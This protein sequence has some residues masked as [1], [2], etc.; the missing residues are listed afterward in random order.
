MVAQQLFGQFCV[1]NQ[2]PQHISQPLLPS[3]LVAET[4]VVCLHGK[5]HG[6][7]CCHSTRGVDGVHAGAPAGA[8]CHKTA[9]AC[10]LCRPGGPLRC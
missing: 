1:A 4:Y 5:S 9:D 2:Q 3:G 7:D 10:E 6:N 8:V